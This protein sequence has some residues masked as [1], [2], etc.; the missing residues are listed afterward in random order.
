MYNDYET[1]FYAIIM[2][3]RECIMVSIRLDDM[4]P[5]GYRFINIDMLTHN[6]EGCSYPLL[7]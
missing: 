1:L 6:W 5:K 7:F 2:S 4:I 3:N